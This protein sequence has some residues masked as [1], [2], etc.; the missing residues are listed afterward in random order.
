MNDKIVRDA[1]LRLWQQ[2]GVKACCGG[3]GLV[4][5][6]PVCGKRWQ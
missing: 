4:V 1:L 6:C 2:L 5:G 3:R